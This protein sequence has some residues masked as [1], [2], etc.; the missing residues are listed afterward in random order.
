[1]LSS[2][3]VP[4]FFGAK[5]PLTLLLRVYS[6]WDFPKGVVERGENPLAAAQREFQEETSIEKVDFPWGHDFF[7]TAPYAHGKIARYYLGRVNS[8]NV[9]LAPNPLTKL[10]EHHEYRWVSFERARGLLVPRVKAVLD[11]ATLR[12]QPSIPA[13][14]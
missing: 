11:W 7:E 3:I 10:T 2:G 13:S 14:I 4:V 1:M 9:I 6:Y 8:Q 12:L 5:G